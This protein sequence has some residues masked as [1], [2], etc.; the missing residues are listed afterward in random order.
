MKDSKLWSIQQVFTEHLLWAFV[1]YFCA[2]T[3]ALVS[4]KVDL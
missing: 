3:L 2:P 1:G 4:G